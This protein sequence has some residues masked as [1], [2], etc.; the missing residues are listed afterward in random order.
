MMKD[1]ALLGRGQVISESVE[2]EEWGGYNN[3]GVGDGDLI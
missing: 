1:K 2:Q 3:G